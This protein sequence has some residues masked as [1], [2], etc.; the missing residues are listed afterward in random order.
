[1]PSVHRG[2]IVGPAAGKIR[3]D[4]SHWSESGLRHHADERGQEH[5]RKQQ[6]Q[7]HRAQGA[8]RL[9]SG[10]ALELSE[11]TRQERPSNTAFE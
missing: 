2:K 11:Y 7:G 6:R 10:V 5:E 1:V 3:R 4:A 8:R 9:T